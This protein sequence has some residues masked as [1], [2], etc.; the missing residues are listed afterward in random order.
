[1][2]RALLLLP[3]ILADVTPRGDFFRPESAKQIGIV[4]IGKEPSASFSFTRDSR[5]LVILT[6]TGKLVV[7]DLA[8][9]R[10]IRQAPGLFFNG[11]ILLSA[12]GTRALGPSQDRRSVR[13]VDL[14]KGVELRTFGD[15]QAAY[16]QSYALSP[17]GRRVATLRR[18]QSIRVS[19]A[20][21]GED[22][23]TLIEPNAGQGGTMAWSPD[24]KLLA[25]H[26][27]DSTIRILDP[28]TGDVAGSFVDMG[29]TPIF[30]GFSPDSSTL[31]LVNQEAK[32]RLVD[33]TGRDI[34]TLDET[35]SGARFIAFSS[36]GRMMAAADVGGKVRIWDTKSW[37]V[38]R[39][40]DATS[41]RHIAFS[42][43]GR[44]LATGSSVG[45][46]RLWGGGGRSTP[47]PGAD[48]ARPGAP[49]FLG[50]SAD[51]TEGEEPGVTISTVIEGTAAEKGGLKVGDRIIRIGTSATDSFEA[52]RTTVISLREGDEVEIVYRRDGAEKKVKVKLG[53]RPGDE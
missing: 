20:A 41:V 35:L 42:P 2:I 32:V 19:D 46:I 30:L 24:G 3:L 52:L 28:A 34:R 45:E 21:T 7:W 47:A 18:D 5:R 44:A 22:V 53:S 10:E 33:K 31:V 27:W 40:L 4:G 25:V 17:D 15:V 51:P 13:L 12:D 36:D 39:D 9:R 49:G 11:R 38:L 14:E 50:I 1:M 43:D 6:T 29:R 37:K 23:K 26:G 8:A 16:L 48:A